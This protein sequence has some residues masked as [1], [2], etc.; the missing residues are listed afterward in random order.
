[1]PVKT[2]AMQVVRAAGQAPWGLFDLSWMQPDEWTWANVEC[3][4]PVE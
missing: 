3:C 4:G 1:M 2:S